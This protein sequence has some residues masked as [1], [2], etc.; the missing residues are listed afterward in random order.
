[1]A[2]QRKGRAETGALPLAVGAGL[3]ENGGTM[4]PAP[5]TSADRHAASHGADFARDWPLDPAIT[6]LNHG[7]FGVTPNSVLEAQEQ[8]RRRIERN[9]TRFLSRELEA[10]LRAASLP[11]ARVV[12]ADPQD[13]VFV[14][15]ATTGLNAVLRCFPFRPGDEILITS[16]VYPAIRK[17][18]RFAAEQSGAQVIEV[19]IPL[20]LVTSGDILTAVSSRLGKRTRLAIF[21]HIA[22]HSALVLPVAELT[23]LAQEAGAQVL[24]D[25]AHVPGMLALDVSALGADWYVGNLHKWFFA[26]R[27]CGFLWAAPAVQA[28][29]HP[30][31]ISHGYG[32][33]FRPE[34]EWTGTRDVTASLSAPAGI[35]FHGRL[36]GSA[37][38]GRNRV[39]AREGAALLARFWGSPLGGP[40]D[41]FAAM[42]TVQLPLTGDCSAARAEAITRELSERHHIEAA[43]VALGDRLWVRIAAQDYNRMSDY[44]NL[45][46]VFRPG[47]A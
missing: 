23:R 39:L 6:Y 24:I 26:P 33:G 16:L 45:A 12:G 22:S 7:G 14:E 38:M 5:E 19:P 17:A 46:A 8:W 18:A 21:D 47:A 4:S 10:E 31:A 34:F 37:L 32:T 1:M 42:V 25:G 41:S 20:P 28:D 2:C 30:L 44:E 15:N 27:S 36:G 40:P 43:V 3:R 35:A 11:V 13:L 9:P 29:L